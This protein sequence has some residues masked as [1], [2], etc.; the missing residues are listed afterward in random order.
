MVDG[1]EEEVMEEDEEEQVF[2]PIPEFGEGQRGETQPVMVDTGRGN[3]E[4]VQPGADFVSTLEALADRAHYGGYYRIFL[5]GS[6]VVNPEDAPET[7]ESGMRLAITS[8][9][10]VG[11]Q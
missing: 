11:S 6:E 9:D 10:K 8:Y 5:N 4:E 3:V 1:Q 2:T 7:I